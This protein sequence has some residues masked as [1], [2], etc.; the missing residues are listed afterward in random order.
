M[1]ALTR[2][3][4]TIP[5]GVVN[6]VETSTSPVFP[7]AAPSPRKSGARP[8]AARSQPDNATHWRIQITNPENTSVNA[9]PPP[10]T[11]LWNT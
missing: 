10:N 7:V 5:M 4:M 8:R 6:H 9:S 11:R 1:P 2:L 3:V